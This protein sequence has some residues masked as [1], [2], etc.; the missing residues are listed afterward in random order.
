MPSAPRLSHVAVTVPRSAF[1]DAPRAELL[2]FYREVFGF[3]ENAELSRDGERIFLRAPHNG[4]YITIRASDKPME[5]SGYEHVGFVVENRDE[6]MAIHTRARAAADRDPRVEVSPPKESYGGTLLG[7]RTRY[8]LP[9]SIEV[10]AF[11]SSSA[12]EHGPD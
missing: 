7:F 10:H 2:A 4:Q 1:Q 8:L 12:R 5:T 6:L 9:L 3:R 11:S